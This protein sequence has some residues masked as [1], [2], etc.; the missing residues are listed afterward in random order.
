MRRLSSRRCWWQA[1]MRG[2]SFFPFSL[3][4]SLS[5]VLYSTFFCY[6][7]HSS[8]SSSSNQVVASPSLVNASLSPFLGT[9]P[10]LKS[11]SRTPV[12]PLSFPFCLL[13]QIGSFLCFFFFLC[14]MLF[15]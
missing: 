10:L 14:R 7:F 9:T 13:C 12:S 15:M 5:A 2:S 6:R 8:C 4:I 3:V 1:Q 11:S